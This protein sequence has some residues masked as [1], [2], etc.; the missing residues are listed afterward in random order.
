MALLWLASMKGFSTAE[1]AAL[2]QWSPL[3]VSVSGLARWSTADKRALVAVIKAKG[4]R[5]ESD[6]VRLFARHRKLGQALLD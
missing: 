3:V 6:Y 2:L 4:G 5:R 1:R